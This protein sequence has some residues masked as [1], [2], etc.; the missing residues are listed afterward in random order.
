MVALLIISKSEELSLVIL[1]SYI[2]IPECCIANTNN[3]T[4]T[5]LG[6]YGYSLML[7]EGFTFCLKMHDLSPPLFPG[8]RSKGQYFPLYFFFPQTI[9]LLVQFITG[10]KII[11]IGYKMVLGCVEL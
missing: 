4:V 1:I 8:I 6:I 5:Y 9:K 11:Q 3:A 7:S 2:I 10:K